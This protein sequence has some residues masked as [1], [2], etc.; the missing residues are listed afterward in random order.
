MQSPA[1]FS[2]QRP[3][4]RALDRDSVETP[5]KTHVASASASESKAS[6][7]LDAPG[8]LESQAVALEAP[9]DR[10]AVNLS[11]GDFCSLAASV[12]NEGTELCESLQKNRVITVAHGHPMGNGESLLVMS[13]CQGK[14]R[15]TSI[16]Y[17]RTHLYGS[18]GKYS[19]HEGQS[20][21]IVSIAHAC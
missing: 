21:S 8:T 14:Q 16:N 6:R 12:W 1:V 5:A 4:P 18:Q 20:L 9:L 2:Q 7:V 3:S 19:G 13:M 17:A 11:E 15:F 10:Q